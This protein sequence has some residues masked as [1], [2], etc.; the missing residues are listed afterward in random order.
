[1]KTINFLIGN[2]DNS[3]KEDYSL[4]RNNYKVYFNNYS[5][6]SKNVN[7]NVDSKEEHSTW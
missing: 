6:Y 4:Y 1:M 5:L 7:I 3:Q 2:I